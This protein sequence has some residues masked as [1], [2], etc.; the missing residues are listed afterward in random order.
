MI[1]GKIDPLDYSGLWCIFEIH[2]N[3]VGLSNVPYVACIGHCT[4]YFCA[5]VL[6]VEHLGFG[7]EHFESMLFISLFTL[8][9]F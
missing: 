6:G 8:L 7:V 1:R 5:C 9:E 3:V 2:I 4:L